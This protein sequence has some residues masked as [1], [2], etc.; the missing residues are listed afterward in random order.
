MDS[1]SVIQKS[2]EEESQRQQSKNVTDRLGSILHNARC[3][4]SPS[5]NSMFKGMSP[6]HG[7]SAEGKIEVVQL[8]LPVS[9]INSSIG[10][11][12]DA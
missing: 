10:R 2:G 7:A 5:V 9:S 12:D 4:N 11:V 3:N 8:D 1:S 6:S